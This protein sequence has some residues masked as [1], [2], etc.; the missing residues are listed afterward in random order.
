MQTM[1]FTAA[2]TFFQSVVGTAM[3]LLANGI[4]RKIAPEDALF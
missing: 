2:A 1:V 3:I 4:V